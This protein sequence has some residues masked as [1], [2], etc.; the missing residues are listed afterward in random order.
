MLWQ[1]V[2]GYIWTATEGGP[3]NYTSINGEIAG[4]CIHMLDA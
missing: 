3:V 4:A 2:S 1:I